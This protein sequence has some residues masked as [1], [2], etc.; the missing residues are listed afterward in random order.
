MDHIRI[1][2]RSYC[3]KTLLVVAAFNLCIGHVAVFNPYIGSGG[4][5]PLPKTPNIG[6]R[7]LHAM[8]LY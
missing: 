4:M 1:G 8:A 7:S 2:W 5:L 3:L 6:Q